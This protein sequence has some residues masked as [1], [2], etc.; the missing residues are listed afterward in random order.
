MQHEG[1]IDK[2]VR[3]TPV[4]DGLSKPGGHM[5]ATAPDS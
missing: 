3:Y 1:V 5:L 4:M 2:N